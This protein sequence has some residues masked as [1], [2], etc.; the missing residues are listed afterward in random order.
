M[1]RRVL[2][3]AAFAIA[4]AWAAPP[5]RYDFA[6]LGGAGAAGRY[7]AVRVGDH[8]MT[9]VSIDAA[10]H[11]G[12]HCNPVPEPA[13]LR[14]PALQ[15]GVVDYIDTAIA[16][17]VVP[18]AHFSIDSYK[19]MTRFVD[20]SAIIHSDY[21][22]DTS[23][24]YILDA[25]NRIAFAAPP[26]P[27]ELQVAIAAALRTL[28]GIVVEQ[29]PWVLQ[30]PVPAQIPDEL[31]LPFDQ[32][33]V[34]KNLTALYTNVFAVLLSVSGY[35]SLSKLT[36][37]EA[38][39]ALNPTNLALFQPTRMA[40]S[41]ALGCGQFYANLQ[42]SVSKSDTLH[43]NSRILSVRRPRSDD[44]DKWITVEFIVAK[45]HVKQR[46]QVK[47]IVLAMPPTA[48]NLEFMDFESDDC[49][50]EQDPIYQLSRNVE[51]RAYFPFAASADVGPIIN[52]SAGITILDF[53]ITSFAPL[54]LSY[55]ALPGIVAFR[56]IVPAGLFAGWAVAD[57]ASISDADMRSVV[58]Q[59]FAAVPPALLS[60]LKLVEFE[61]HNYAPYCKLSA[62][63]SPATNCYEKLRLAQGNRNTFLI[64]AFNAGASSALVWQDAENVLALAL[65]A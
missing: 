9:S 40:M 57:D 21:T 12:G 31:L 42:A 2:L 33:M 54:Q 64:G 30:G 56:R 7:F 43:L 38:L 39:Q 14:L 1:D 6:I 52:A 27:P 44:D 8:N 46:V 34:I 55:P 24:Q 61:R 35:G 25:V 49:S 4:C 37:F 62:L 51:Q 63:A 26:P 53:A 17:A 22:G 19:F 11:V 5:K 36:T 15:I 13:S 29:Y 45:S 16:N 3:F 50:A 10:D 48:S 23:G 32:Y 28:F 65:A 18:G 20:P 41:P 59:Q 60:N 47:K 58:L